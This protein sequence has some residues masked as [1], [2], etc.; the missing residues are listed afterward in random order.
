MTGK[1][2]GLKKPDWK[3]RALEYGKTLGIIT[4]VA[5]FLLS[6][7][8]VL[9][10]KAREHQERRAFQEKVEELVGNVTTGCKLI[11][12]EEGKVIGA[13]AYENDPTSPEFVITLGKAKGYGDYVKVAAAISVKKE[14]G[15]LVAGEVEGVAIVDASKETPGLG[16]RVSEKS[17]LDRFRGKT[18]EQLHVGK[19][20]VQ[21]ITGATI[22]S[23]AAV[24]AT[25]RAFEKAQKILSN[26][27]QYTSRMEDCE[28]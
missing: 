8:N 17:F 28:K 16:S 15:K 3:K 4:A 20:G 18:W 13:I 9:T 5:A 6:V 25:R 11:L 21:A 10:L 22:S 14:N 1:N 27:S 2:N 23:T 19:D 24:K 12:D 7:A 26:F